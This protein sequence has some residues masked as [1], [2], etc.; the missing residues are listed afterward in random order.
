MYAQLDEND[1]CI[2]VTA[3]KVYNVPEIN[4]KLENLGQKWDG[5]QWLS[6][7]EFQEVTGSEYFET[8]GLYDR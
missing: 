5:K 1:I 8:E 3:D 6:L 2:A 4:A 7:S